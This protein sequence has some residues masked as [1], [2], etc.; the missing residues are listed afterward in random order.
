M[1]YI[2]KKNSDQHWEGD[3]DCGTTMKYVPK[4]SLNLGTTAIVNIRDHRDN[5]AERQV[6]LWP[7]DDIPRRELRSYARAMMGDYTELKLTLDDG[8]VI[9]KLKEHFSCGNIFNQMNDLGLKSVCYNQGGV[10]LEA[11]CIC[12]M[13]THQAKDM[14]EIF[15]NS[16]VI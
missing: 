3:W 10:W 11:W 4:N 15:P 5:Q 12:V 8:H 13:T 6:I 1:K 9:M 14:G 2:E 16:E 7:H